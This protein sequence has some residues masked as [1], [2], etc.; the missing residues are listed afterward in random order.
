MYYKE[1]FFVVRRILLDVLA[2]KVQELKAGTDEEKERFAS[3][4]LQ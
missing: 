2:P 1:R 3:L 4:L